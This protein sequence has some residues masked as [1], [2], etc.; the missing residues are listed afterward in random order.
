MLNRIRR[1]LGVGSDTASRRSEAASGSVGTAT[2]FRALADA[3]DNAATDWR[4]TENSLE[5]TDEPPRSRISR[6]HQATRSDL[7]E[8]RAL[9]STVAD[10]LRTCAEIVLH[11][12]PEEGYVEE[13]V[14]PLL[15]SAGNGARGSLGYVL[16]RHS[17]AAAA[18]SR[19]TVATGERQCGTTGLLAG[20][21]VYAG[22]LAVLCDRGVGGPNPATVFREASEAVLLRASALHHAG[23]ERAVA[24]LRTLESASLRRVRC[25]RCSVDGYLHVESDSPEAGVR[26]H[27]QPLFGF[28]RYTLTGTHP[29]LLGARVCFNCNS[30]PACGGDG[31]TAGWCTTCTPAMSIAERILR[32]HPQIGLPEFGDLRLVREDE[33][34]GRTGP[35]AAEP[36]PIG[37]TIHHQDLLSQAGL[38]E[39]ARELGALL[40]ADY[41]RVSCP[42]CGSVGWDHVDGRGRVIGVEPCGGCGVCLGCG[43]SVTDGWCSTCTPA[44]ARRTRA[45]PELRSVTPEPVEEIAQATVAMMTQGL[46]LQMAGFDDALGEVRVLVG[47]DL[48]RV[49]CPRCNAGGWT[50]ADRSGTTIGTR[51]CPECGACLGCGRRGSAGGWCPT[52]TPGLASAATTL[53]DR[54]AG[55]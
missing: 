35:D 14:S 33:G 42:A 41:R 39:V 52:C 9:A 47:A 1:W 29:G 37:A 16:R 26:E 32:E 23:F 18:A 3:L 19:A 38:A 12:R 49:P 17:Y 11:R 10:G 54:S 31:Q 46:V 53:A 7:R 28:P 27:S 50:H 40:D 13:V 4:V 45:K 34:A 22:R 44:M 5:R 20:E 6:Q 43:R 15:A 36:V 51:S 30:C 8:A 48:V 24:D 21:A 2:I 25:W 55:H